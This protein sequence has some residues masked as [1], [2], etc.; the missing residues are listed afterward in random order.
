MLAAS[1]DVKFIIIAAAEWEGKWKK[2]P[3]RQK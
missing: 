2:S 3:K 1:S